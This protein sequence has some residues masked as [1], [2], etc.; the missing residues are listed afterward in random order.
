[1]I[2]GFGIDDLG[3]PCGDLYCM[4]LCF[5]V[6][7]KS[8]DPSSKCGCV[9]IDPH[10]GIL[11]AGYNSPPQGATDAEIP[12]TRPDKYI[13]FEH[14]ER[15]CI[16][17]AARNGTPLRGSIFYVTGFPC[18]DCLRAMIQVEASKIIYGPYQTVMQNSE[19]YMKRYPILLKGQKIVIKRFKYDEGLYRFNPRIQVLM[20]KRDVNDIHFEWN[21]CCKSE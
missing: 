8:L 2:D 17:L 7:R 19:E 5:E 12:L 10:G 20:E 4:N 18:S 13:Y 21:V 1:M 14:S 6:A 11:S 9:A 16:Y 15:N 3:R